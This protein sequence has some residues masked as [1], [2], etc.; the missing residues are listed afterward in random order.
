MKVTILNTPAYD[1]TEVIYEDF[2]AQ[3]AGPHSSKAFSHFFHKLNFFPITCWSLSINLLLFY[4]I[5]NRVCLWER[6]SEKEV[7]V[8]RRLARLG[9]GRLVDLY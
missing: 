8:E 4:L 3:A 1:R 6:Q 5:S 7:E 9:I 2:V